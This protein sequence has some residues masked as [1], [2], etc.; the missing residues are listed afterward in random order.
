MQERTRRTIVHVWWSL[1]HAGARRRGNGMRCGGCKNDSDDGVSL[2]SRN[3]RR[4]RR[5]AGARD[6]GENR[7]GDRDGELGMRMVA[8]VRTS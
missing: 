5:N 6:Q 2:W 7:D 3:L 4:C 1:P 8:G